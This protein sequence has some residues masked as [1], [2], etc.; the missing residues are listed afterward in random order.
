MRATPVRAGD[1]KGD[2][3]QAV[4]RLALECEATLDDHHLVQMA[5]SFPR[6]HHA[7]WD[8]LIALILRRDQRQDFIEGF[9]NSCVRQKLNC[10]RIKITQRIC[11]DMVGE[12]VKEQMLRQMKWGRSPHNTAPA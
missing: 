4:E 5:V 7:G 1:G 12:H 2:L 8:V 9:D 6:Q 3:R 10:W 11:L